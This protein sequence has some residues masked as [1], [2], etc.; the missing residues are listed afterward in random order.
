MRRVPNSCRMDKFD[1]FHLQSRNSSVRTRSTVRWN[2]RRRSIKDR[3]Q[4]GMKGEGKGGRIVDQKAWRWRENSGGKTHIVPRVN[5]ACNRK[6]AGSS[7]YSSW[8][9]FKDILRRFGRRPTH[10]QKFYA[11]F[12]DETAAKF[13]ILLFILILLTTNLISWIM[14]KIIN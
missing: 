8:R 11:H 1:L 3:D 12:D 10:L 5:A 2:E 7:E 13:Y 6:W 14:N 9:S 4:S